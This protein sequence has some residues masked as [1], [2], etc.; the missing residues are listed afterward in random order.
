MTKQ[1]IVDELARLYRLQQ[2]GKNVQK[3]IEELEEKLCE[4]MGCEETE[5]GDPSS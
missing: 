4:V 1:Q 5:G 3:L 2:E